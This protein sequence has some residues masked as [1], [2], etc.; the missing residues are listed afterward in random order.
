MSISFGTTLSSEE[1]EPRRLVEMARG[2]EGAGFDFVSISDHLHPWVDAQ[3]HSPFVWSVLSAISAVTERI[4]VGVGVTCPILRFHPL[5]AAH[6]SATTARL[7]PGRFTFG[8]GSG[9]ALNEH[10]YRDGVAGGGDPP[11][12]AGGGLRADPGAVDRRRRHPSRPL[13]P[14]VHG[15]PLRPSRAAAT[16][17]RVGVRPGAAEV[18]ARCG[19]GLWTHPT[20]VDV[21]EAFR[22]AGGTGPVYAQVNLCW[23]ESESEARSIAHRLWPNTGLSGQLARTCRRRS[24]SRWRPTVTEE[25]VAESVPCGPDAGPVLDAVAAAID[26]GVDHVYLH[27]I[28]EDQDGFLRFWC[29]ELRPALAE[30]SA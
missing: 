23:N 12:D 26:A 8:I 29:E 20:S 27:Q 18:A 3:G 24:T 17:R 19:D 15:P 21:I 30:R 13:L 16:A 10:V 4:E 25:M 28:G 22:E 14:R 9:E 7:M 1:H 2:A 5:L 11:R 6:A